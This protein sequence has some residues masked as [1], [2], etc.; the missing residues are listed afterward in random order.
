MD[1]ARDT[2]RGVQSAST[3]VAQATEWVT[4]ALIATTVVAVLA[5]ALSTILLLGK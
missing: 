3:Q 4:V 1:S 5:L 2:L